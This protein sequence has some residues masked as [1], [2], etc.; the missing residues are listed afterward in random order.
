MTRRKI[1]VATVLT[2]AAGVA[3]LLL[4]PVQTAIVGWVTGGIDGAEITVGRVSAGPWGADIDDIRVVGPVFELRVDDVDVDLAFWSSLGHLRAEVATATVT[5]LHI[6][7]EPSSAPSTAASASTADPVPFMGLSPVVR[8]PNRLL[9]HHAEVEGSFEIVVSDTLRFEGPLAADL[10]DLGPGRQLTASAKSSIRLLQSGEIRAAA[11]L[12]S[13]IEVTVDGVGAVDHATAEAEI[14][15]LSGSQPGLRAQV[16]TDLTGP[17]EAYEFTVHTAREHR[18]V[19]VAADF[20][21]EPRRLTTR[22]TASVPPGVLA[23]FARGR[24]LPELDLESTGEADLALDAQRLKVRATGRLAGRDWA[25]LDPR[26]SEIDDLV[27]EGVVVATGIGG[28]VDTEEL[29]LVLIRAG[30]RPLLTLEALQPVSTDSAD[31]SVTPETWGEPTFR[32]RAQGFPL[33]WTRGFDS[34]VLVEGGSLSAAI[35]VVPLAPGRTRIAAFEPIRI[36]DLVLNARDTPAQTVALDLTVDP[37]VTLGRGDL[38]ASIHRATLTST[39]GLDVGFGG[40]VTTSR[41]RWPVLDLKGG[42]SFHLPRLQ[43]FVEA[44][45][46]VSGGV[47]VALDLG[48][49][50]LATHEA[51][52]T[53]ADPQRNTVLDIRLDN[54]Q[55]LLFDLATMR[56]DWRVSGHQNVRVVVND[57]PVA[58][59][60]AFLPELEITDGIFRGELHAAAGG[61]RGLTLEPVRPFEVRQL[62]PAYRGSAF[63]SDS[64]ASVEPRFVFNSESVRF[65]L[66]NFRIRTADRGRV[67]AEFALEIPREGDGDIATSLFVEAEFPGVTGRIGNL[68]ALSWRQRG[69]LR[70]SDRRIDVDLLE[71]GLTDAAGIRFLELESTRPFA[72]RTA[73]FA[74]EAS[75]GSPD[76][77]SATVVP[78]ELQQLFPEVLGLRLEGVLP[79]GEFVGRV[80][81]GGLLLLA[82]DPLVFRDVTV[83]WGQAPLLDRVTVGLSYQVRYSDTGLEARSIDFGVLGPRGTPI[84]D[85]TLKAVMPLTDRSA[86]DRVD[87]EVLANLEPLTRQP[88]LNG[89]PDFTDGT[90]GGAL[91]FVHGEPTTIAVDLA[92]HAP[93]MQ[94]GATLPDLTAGFKLESL[95]GERLELTAPIRMESAENG[96]SDL[97]FASQVVRSNGHTTIDASLAGGRLAVPDVLRF[98][99]LVTPAADDA[100]APE[101][102]AT[103]GERAPFSRTALEQLRYRRDTEPVWG[104][105]LSGRVSMDFDEIQLRLAAIHGLRGRLEVTPEAVSLTETGATFLGADLDI[106][107]RLAFNADAAQ[108][109]DLRVDSSFT[110]LDLG[111]LFRIVAP[112]E[113]PLLEGLFDV[114]ATAD[115]QGRNLADLGVGALGSVRISGRDGVYRGLAGRYGLVRSGVKAI[116]FLTF[117]KQLKAIGRLMEE[118]EAL[119]FDTLE[120]E[121]ARDDPARFGISQFALTSPLVRINGSG[122]I[123]VTPDVPLPASALEARLD[124]ATAGDVS[125]LFEGLG[126]IAEDDSGDG[127]R[128]LSRPVVIGGTVA[129]PDTSDFYEMLDQAAGESEGVVGVAMRRVN[130][131]LQRGR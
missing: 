65:A 63:A 109:Y 27:A 1:A 89:L 43:A 81:D 73:P 120:V 77:M 97:R 26:L 100:A 80:E 79:Q 85:A 127:Y 110:G 17:N 2:L 58:W 30:D 38:E 24:P 21:P 51:A 6:R 84:A 35:D 70:P 64:T 50:T 116:G 124:L 32:M 95:A 23:A 9:V 14:S 18:L 106:A 8:L 103:R 118:L 69:S 90:I 99:E 104:S 129:E 74:I 28:R 40:Q 131:K 66:D 60:S 16:S 47:T 59:M 67:D 75:G 98:V 121:L 15:A 105:S 68:G 49:L 72:V 10:T 82:E 76:I 94:G 123:E 56:P 4:P 88:I 7:L 25:D 112:E 44:V 31:W 117:S 87:F 19:E 130:K 96:R 115:G 62:S 3:I 71:I 20:E 33:R 86:L 55:P 13:N 5:G 108:P 37:E 119:R 41:E 111:A 42:L 128:P 34:A 83:S 92:L 29:R 114:T 57:F 52:L 12:A 126:L 113:Q 54:E 22:W 48:G 78:L 91:S 45:D 53:V 101:P 107:G 102:T 122:G 39:K 61:G 46:R 93:R 36:S 11:E 125:I